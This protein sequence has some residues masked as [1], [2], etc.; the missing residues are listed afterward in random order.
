MDVDS[1]LAKIFELLHS[2]E[3]INGANIALVD[4][5]LRDYDKI[6]DRIGL[7]LSHLSRR[8][9]VSADLI[10]HLLPYHQI[11]LI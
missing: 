2:S 8:W 7:I 4:G 3:L 11:F 10:D 9:I 5:V 6:V 1:P